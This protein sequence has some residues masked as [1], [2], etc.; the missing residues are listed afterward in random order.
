L[1]GALGTG[2][3]TPQNPV[4]YDL[5][6]RVANNSSGVFRCSFAL[7]TAEGDATTWDF[8]IQFFRTTNSDTFYTVGK[9]IDVKASGLATD[10]NTFI[11]NTVPGTYGTEVSVLMRVTD[12]G[13]ES[14]TYN[15][16]VQL[17]FDGGFTW[18]YDTE[19]DSNLPNGWRLKG[20]GR[21]VMWDIAPDAGPVTYDDF[22]LRMVPV[23]ATL[24]APADGAQNLGAAAP[25]TAYVSNSA[26]G[27]VTV[28]YYT[29]QAPRP[30]PGPDFMIV[31]LPDTQNYARESAGIGDA[32]KEMWFAPTGSSAI[33]LRLISFTSCN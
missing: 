28:T 2:A 21:Y 6:I 3:A 12:A 18:F 25:L 22:S 32:K 33:A 27:N 30:F 17:S 16:R 11:T 19:L 1:A 7:G 20:T 15:S 9:R 5:S 24:I 29:R 4:V 14:T 10:L 8:G 26:P 23:S 13:N 31:A